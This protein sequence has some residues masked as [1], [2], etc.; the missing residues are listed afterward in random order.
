MD[1]QQ[2]TTDFPL[3]EEFENRGALSRFNSWIK[4]HSR[5]ITSL[6]IIAVI[7]GVG[8]YAYNKPREEQATTSTTAEQTSEV[9]T[10]ESKPEIVVAQPT[11]STSAP[12]VSATENVSLVKRAVEIKEEAII[13]SAIRGDGVT[14]L[15]REALREYLKADSNI[16]L[17][18]E[19]KIYI[20]DFLKDKTASTRIA[21]GESK[22]F[23]KDTIK[24]A[25]D[26]AQN[27]TEKQIQNLTQYTKLVPELT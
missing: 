24:Q 15:A 10:E 27:L 21:T 11:E 5:A 9:A 2:T 20:E 17:S 12:T 26:R 6:I 19:Q 16:K 14:H 3:P 4:D 13:V 8:I 23:S 7:I 18:A 22:T 25:V 1:E